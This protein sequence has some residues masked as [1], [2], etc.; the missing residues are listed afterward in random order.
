MPRQNLINMAWTKEIYDEL[1]AR[2][3]SSGLN[4]RDFCYNEGISEAKFYYWK[5]RS[6]LQQKCELVRTGGFIPVDVAQQGNNFSIQKKQITSS[7]E[8]NQTS[9]S[10]FEITYPNGVTVRMSGNLSLDVYKALVLLT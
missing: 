10:Y 9:E 3:Q 2:F 1:Y 5:R 7:I 8:K 6:Q 4:I